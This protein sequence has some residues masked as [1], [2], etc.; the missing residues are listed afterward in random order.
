LSGQRKAKADL[1]RLYIKAIVKIALRRA[2]R[3]IGG[4]VG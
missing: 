3:I 4:K 2:E 1:F